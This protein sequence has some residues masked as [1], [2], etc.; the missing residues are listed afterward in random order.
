MAGRSMPGRV[1]STK[2]AVAISA[3]VLPADTA[4]CASPAFTCSMATRMDESFLF[5]SAD[6]GASSI[7]TTCVAW[8]T[9][10]LSSGACAAASAACRR[11]S[12]PTIIRRASGRRARKRTAAGTVT[13]RPTSPPIA[14]TDRVI[15]GCVFLLM[16]GFRRLLSGCLSIESRQFELPECL[17]KQTAQAA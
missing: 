16:F 15:I 9:V 2:R 8:R 10:I 14:S 4:A 7:S 6:C 11:L 1:L 13:S 12:S 17:V 3:P 5:F